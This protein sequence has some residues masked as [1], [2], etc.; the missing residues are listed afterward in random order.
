MPEYVNNFNASSTCG[1]GIVE[2]G[3]ECDCG[4]APDRVGIDVVLNAYMYM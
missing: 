3:E 1:N 4:N 2:N